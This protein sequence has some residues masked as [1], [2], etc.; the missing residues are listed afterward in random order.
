VRERSRRAALHRFEQ[1]EGVHGIVARSGPVPADAAWQ[2][3]AAALHA[4]A[5]DAATAAHRRHDQARHGTAGHV[6]AIARR[7]PW[8]AP[9]AIAAVLG[10]FAVGGMRW[11]DRSS[12]ATRAVSALAASEA[13]VRTTRPGERATLEL[14]DGTRAALGGSATLR[15]PRLYGP[16]LRAVA[17]DGSA[18]FVVAPGSERPFHVQTPQAML[19]ATGTAFDVR[20]FAADGR[21]LVRVREGTVRVTA[22]DG[23]RSLAAGEA[24]DVRPDGT[25]R[26]L[27]AAA[28]R[29]AFAWQEGRLAV[30]NR[31]LREALV[32]VERW[33]GLTLHVRDRALLDRP[34]TLDVPFGATRA[35][36]GALEQGSGLAFAWEGEQMTLRAQP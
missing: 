20:A 18:S 21:T 30:T 36:L 17:L 15:I 33:F 19:V 9:V 8:A 11:M 13:R 26:P 7:R 28:A 10:A 6:A 35:L 27:A 5:V 14:L 12:D 34:V 22:G 25:M 24:L 31:P 1:H 16:A 2:H 4:P 32:E 29:E 3:V 23:T